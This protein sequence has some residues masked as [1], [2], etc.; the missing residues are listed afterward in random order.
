MDPTEPIPQRFWQQNLDDPVELPTLVCP[1]SG[2]RY[3]PWHD[4][5][6]VF[7]KIDHL[8]LLSKRV[9]FITDEIHNV[10]EP[11]RIAYSSEPYEVIVNWAPMDDVGT[12]LQEDSMTN[13]ELVF[14]A[15]YLYFNFSGTATRQTRQEFLRDVDSFRSWHSVLRREL[16]NVEKAVALTPA[17]YTRKDEMLN[18]FNVLEGKVEWYDKKNLHHNTL[19]QVENNIATPGPRM[20]VVLPS[21]LE[22]WDESNPAT[23]SFRCY[24]LCEVKHKDWAGD[25]DYAQCHLSDHP[26]YDLLR[27]QEFFQRHGDYALRV[28]RIVQRGHSESDIMVP[29][30]ETFEIL[31]G[32]SSSTSE[33]RLRKDTLGHLVSKS[34]AYIENLG[35]LQ[36]E[37]LGLDHQEIRGI[38]EFL[39]IEGDEQGL[40]DLFRHIREVAP[41]DVSFW[42]C[43][44]HFQQVA[45][46]E[47]I[48]ELQQIVVHDF[49]GKLDLHR[50]FIQMEL[51]D[52]SEATGLAACIEE[53]ATVF[54]VSITLT[55]PVTRKSLKEFSSALKTAQVKWLELDGVTVDVYPEGSVEYESDLFVEA[56]QRFL[57]LLNYPRHGEQYTIVDKISFQSPMPKCQHEPFCWIR[58]ALIEDST[59]DQEEEGRD[60]GEENGNEEDHLQKTI[61]KMAAIIRDDLP[62]V[63]WTRTGDDEKVET[64][65]LNSGAI[66]L[67]LKEDIVTSYP[68]NK[69]RF[70]RQMT[71]EENIP[72]LDSDFVA[73]LQRSQ[74]LEE[75]NVATQGKCPL[76]LA[77]HL[78]EACQ[79]GSMSLL[80]TLFERSMD[81]DEKSR[82]I[83]Q[84]AIDASCLP[85]K[86]S[87]NVTEADIDQGRRKSTVQ[88]RSYLESIE[89]RQWNSDI[90]MTPSSP[91]QALLLDRWTDAFPLSLK[92]FTLDIA[93][94]S[95]ETLLALQSTLRR[96]QLGYLH[97]TCRPMDP[98][99]QEPLRQVLES[100]EWSSIQLLVLDG[101]CTEP[102]VELL[103][104]I[105]DQR[106][107]DV[108]PLYLV[109]EDNGLS[110]SPLSHS[111]A[112][113]LHRL[114]YSRSLDDVQLKN[115]QFQ[116]EKDRQFVMD[117][118][119]V[120]ASVIA[121]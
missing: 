6:I 2:I 9:P 74:H 54:D 106:E 37:Q 95:L 81:K 50:G 87:S 1:E 11:L 4:I 16:D 107:L 13:A 97:I 93:G 19:C 7:D 117:A 8:L 32:H 29:P 94:R 82:I 41:N 49:G 65:Y 38:K 40:G 44:T 60:A 114:L 34:I 52:E 80:L 57:T 92:F 63:N 113:A 35:L 78:I 69:L 46:I 90:A 68:S 30:L 121:C 3:V 120:N 96:S 89:C 99:L 61:Q 118:I 64:F 101:E 103:A 112:L 51:T 59:R 47:L 53:C 26:G 31:S 115:I 66:E 119:E 21:N 83:V 104:A 72:I 91:E 105:Y 48:E 17:Y 25:E 15:R 36:K 23:H 22:S 111:G 102:W 76:G 62:Q 73:L 20:I 10:I 42:V 116:D 75:L 18:E 33:K 43:Q 58:S 98:S 28:L 24:F 12:P 14:D 88:P 85:K 55:C 70:L 27:P 67:H 109:V 86:D 108:L 39:Y 5:N 77:E 79:S 56:G 84:M 71:V 110:P 100:I 45:N